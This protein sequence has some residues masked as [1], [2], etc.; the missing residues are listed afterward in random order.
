MVVLTLS[1]PNHLGL[2]GDGD[3]DGKFDNY[4]PNS[5]TDAI[6]IYL[7]GNDSWYQTVSGVAATTGATSIIYTGESGSILVGE[8]TIC[9]EMGHCLGMEHTFYQTACGYSSGTAYSEHG[10][11]TSTGYIG[12]GDWGGD[13][14]KDTWPDPTIFEATSD[15]N[16]RQADGYIFNASCINGVTA[17]QTDADGFP[18]KPLVNNYMDYGYDNIC[19]PLQFTPGQVERMKATIAND[20]VVFFTTV[21]QQTILPI[22]ATPD[23][24][25]QCLTNL[26]PVILNATGSQIYPQYNWAGYSTTDNFYIINPQ[27]TTTTY[28]VV[29]RDGCTSA[30]ASYTIQVNDGIALSILGGN[31]IGSACAGSTNHYDIDNHGNANYTN[32]TWTVTAGTGSINS[33]GDLTIAANATGSITINYSAT[34]VP[35][36]CNLSVSKTITIVP[37][38][39][40]VSIISNAINDKI[41]LGATTTLTATGTA[42]LSYV[43]STGETGDHIDVFPTTA[44]IYSVIA[45]SPCGLPI[46]PAVITISIS[47]TPSLSIT[48]FQQLICVDPNGSTPIQYSSNYSDPLTYTVAW[49]TNPLSINDVS[50]NAPS[51]IFHPNQAGIFNLYGKIDDNTT[52]CNSENFIPITILTNNPV[53]LGGNEICTGQQ[54][55]LTVANAP[56][57]TWSVSPT[58]KATIDPATGVLSGIADGTV[59]VSYTV[60]LCG[61]QMVTPNFPVVISLTPQILQ[62]ANQMCLSVPSYTF[63]ANVGGA[64]TINPSNGT[65]LSIVT[66]ST[67][68]RIAT[69]FTNNIGNTT[70]RFEPTTYNPCLSDPISIP[71]TVIDCI[72]P[73]ACT[74]VPSVTTISKGI[75]SNQ[76]FYNDLY[77][78]DGNITIDGNV[79]FENAQV[80]VKPGATITV[81]DNATL[82]ITS[83]HFYSCDLMWQGIRASGDEAK[84]KITG[85]YGLSSLIEDAEIA[86]QYSAQNPIPKY[87]TGKIVSI[88]NTIFNR[89][90]VGINIENVEED[91]NGSNLP[92]SI[93]NC[94]FTSRNIP[95]D[96]SVIAW[97]GVASMKFSA[98][99]A[100]TAFGATPLT[101]ASPYIDDAVYD[102]AISKAF[103]NDGSNT[104]PQTAILL[105]DVGTKRADGTFSNIVIGGSIGYF[106]SNGP[107]TNTTIFDN[108]NIGISTNNS[109]IV[110]HNCTFQKPN[111]IGSIVNP[112]AI[113]I[114]VINKTATNKTRNSIEINSEGYPRNAFFDLNTAIYAYR[115]DRIVINGCDIRTSQDVNTIDINNPTSMGNAGIV[116]STPDY[117]FASIT[118]NKIYNVQ[119]GLWF[120][121]GIDRNPDGIGNAYFGELD[122]SNNV[123]ARI[124]QGAPTNV[125]PANPNYNITPYLKNA[126]NIE[127]IIYGDAT[128]NITCNNNQITDAVNGI[129]LSGWKGATISNNNISIAQDTYFVPVEE[130][131]GIS[132]EGGWGESTNPTIIQE[133]ILTG[134]NKDAN[135]TGILVSQA[136]LSNIGCNH[137]GGELQNGNPTPTIGFKNG[138][139]F[140]G[141]NAQTKFWDNTMYSV[142]LYGLTLS[143]G[144]IIGKQ[145]N[146]VGTVSDPVCTS[147]NSWEQ[148]GTGWGISQYMTYCE[149]SDPTNSP[150]VYLNRSNGLNLQLI[151]SKNTSSVPTIP[152][153]IYGTLGSLFPSSTTDPSCTRCASA[154]SYR[155]KTLLQEIA[156]GT[157]SL[158]MD[159]ADDRLLVM[160]QQLYELLQSNPE[161]IMNDTTLQQFIYDNQWSSLDFIHYAAR[162]VAEERWDLVQMLLGAWPGQTNLDQTYHHYFEWLKNMHDIPEWQPNIGE[163]RELA[164]KCPMKYGTVIF[165]VRNLCNALTG[166]INEFRDNC[167]DEARGVTKQKGFIRLKQRKSKVELPNRSG[168]KNKLVVYPNPTTGLVNIEYNKVKQVSI[169]DVTG[170]TIMTT[171]WDGNNDKVQ[172]NVN[173][174]P[175]GLYIINAID[176]DNKKQSQKL[177]KNNE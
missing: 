150:L 73:V 105:K 167:D 104:K 99:T 176:A 71:V 137:V 169:I 88:D 86:V 124:L 11:M 120:N 174:L 154:S 22:A 13:F 72:S 48:P 2:V 61:N 42:G 165:A 160:Q 153:T 127:A 135:T 44:T 164:N 142:N 125:I 151:P 35:T 67:D 98:A 103:L 24:S 173:N 114:S 46:P 108:H 126:I 51:Y 115:N 119:N 84:I 9:H 18:W 106:S 171:K 158:P 6:D 49:R 90:R 132:L 143:T 21:H 113:G 39:S 34:S 94:I 33:T 57:G 4:H 74:N 93:S 161:L 95:F 122:V 100:S 70:V 15:G 175:R 27:P 112:D 68:S 56:G 26:T 66:S 139:R 8:R 118:N 134:W 38:N 144:G 133:N 7:L 140:V 54:L 149:D 50:G 162:Y 97:N 75:V 30:T 59:N 40:T 109:N 159:D 107:Q 92:F 170:R 77:Y 52:H 155:I 147:N 37:Q 60:N 91:F 168:G 85:S 31:G 64:W 78:I 146:N 16:C 43:W 121:S 117:H 76:N 89:N 65:V 136:T 20:D 47:Q 129:K 116:V 10:G 131:Y 101:Y 79:N 156:D 152:S 83:S 110:V 145:G 69:V 12:N 1:Y 19:L 82:S 45:T 58:S 157:V 62:S 3:G 53:I 130:Q 172:L 81:N 128:T 102:D 55:S 5:S 177:I 14:V 80:N 63:R 141:S 25:H 29:A 23:L 32:G 87:V 36:G 17:T 163:V 138:F 41:C 166:E 123:L 28:T 96:P 148:P 111:P